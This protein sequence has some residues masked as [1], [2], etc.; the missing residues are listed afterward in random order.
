MYIRG[1]FRRIVYQWFSPHK[2]IAVRSIKRSAYRD[3]DYLMVETVFQ[4]FKNFV[5][6][7]YEGLGGLNDAIDDLEKSRFDSVG[8]GRGAVW[9]LPE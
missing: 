5:D 7:E 3:M 4:L 8:T 2:L 9:S 6:N 1:W